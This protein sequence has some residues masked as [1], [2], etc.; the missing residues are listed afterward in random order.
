MT[1]SLVKRMI[2]SERLS[3]SLIKLFRIFVVF[4]LPKRTIIG[5]RRQFARVIGCTGKTVSGEFSC[6]SCWVSCC[7][8]LEDLYD[9]EFVGIKNQ[10]R[11]AIVASELEVQISRSAKVNQRALCSL[12]CLLDGD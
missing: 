9:R 12:Y 6:I 5:P 7:A 11:R 3:F 10:A 8:D 1:I 2:A 4:L